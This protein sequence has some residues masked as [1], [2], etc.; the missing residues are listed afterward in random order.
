VVWT[1]GCTLACPG[2]FNP[3]THTAGGTPRAV[4]E[5]ADEIGSFGVEGVTVSGGEPLEQAEAVLELARRCRSR[6]LSVLVLTG[7]TLPELRRRRPEVAAG[8]ARHVDVVVAGRYVAARRLASGL[9]GSANKTVHL[10]SDR[11]QLADLEAVPPAEVMISPDGTVTFTGVAPLAGTAETVGTVG[12]Q[13]SD[14]S[15]SGA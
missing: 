14:Q 5:L 8:L 6:G 12:G 4:A 15:T 3:G 1:Q 9:R 13:P 11:Y 7:F 2:C 10:M